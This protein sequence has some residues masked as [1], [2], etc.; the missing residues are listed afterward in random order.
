MGVVES[1]NQK[2]DTLG[3]RDSDGQVSEFQVDN[4]VAIFKNDKEI[5]LSDVKIGD[6][7]TLKRKKH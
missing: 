7:V 4:T 6:H 1:A 5:S 3:V 2:E